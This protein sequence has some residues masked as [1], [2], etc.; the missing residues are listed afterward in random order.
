[1]KVPI[2]VRVMPT[3][4]VC[5]DIGDVSNT[6]GNLSMNAVETAANDVNRI[7]FD[8]IVFNDNGEADVDTV[9]DLCGRCRSPRKAL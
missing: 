2:L 6:S 5:A 1:M 4:H 3:D 9:I 8:K 7:D